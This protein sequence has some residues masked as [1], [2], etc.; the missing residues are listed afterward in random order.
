MS[1]IVQT[2]IEDAWRSILEDAA[3]A[4]E[5]NFFALGGDSL[6]AVEL[7]EKV[8]GALGIEFPLDILFLDGNLNAIVEEC[9]L[10]HAQAPEAT[11]AAGS[12]EG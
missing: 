2:V 1:D 10:R 6:S 11:A 12:A 3:C 5:D 8:E 9:R 4:P 7:M